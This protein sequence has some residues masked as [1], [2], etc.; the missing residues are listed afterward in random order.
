MSDTINNIL[1]TMRTKKFALEVLNA[2]EQCAG[3][4]FYSLY[5]LGGAKTVKE[6]GELAEDDPSQRT[7]QITVRVCHDFEYAIAK[8]LKDS[9]GYEI[10]PKS[11]TNDIE[12][13][14][15][16]AI[17][18][19]DTVLAFEVK[20]T[21][22]SNGWTGSTH[23][24][25]CGKVPFYILIQYELDLDI[26]LGSQ[27]LYG[28]FKSCHFSVTSPLQDGSAIIQWMGQATESNSRTT[29]KIKKSDSELY[30]PMICL[31]GVST[32]NCRKW[33]KTIKEDLIEY[34]TGNG[35]SLNPSY[36]LQQVDIETFTCEIKEEESLNNQL[37]LIV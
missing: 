18:D 25:G 34:R 29:G 16:V 13:N 15:D 17:Q 27:S 10:V 26:E 35:G 5:H 37:K 28:L 14:F 36:Y 12:G 30:E 24:T 11:G 4:H 19:G 33:T 6:W 3:Y 20:T 1:H 7:S 23:S 22:S 8:V 21:Q 9:Y 2:V 32:K 31:G